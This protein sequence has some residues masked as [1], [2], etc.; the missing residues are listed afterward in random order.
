MNKLIFIFVL[1]FSCISL[2]SQQAKGYVIK[3][4]RNNK[5]YYVNSGS[6]ITIYTQDTKEH[7]FLDSVVN[8]KIY[9]PQKEFSFNQIEKIK[10]KFK[11]T[12][13]EWTK[14]AIIMFAIFAPLYLLG[15]ML[16]G[17]IGVGTAIILTLIG[18]AG[19]IALIPIAIIAIIKANKTTIRF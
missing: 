16:T 11:K 12:G 2:Y 6:E 13:K 18:Y 5:K 19:L 15:F 9:T 8:E 17:I 14:T 3:D 7:A 10:I 1:L 4:S